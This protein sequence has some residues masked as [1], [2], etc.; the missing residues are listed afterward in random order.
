M[1]E[2]KLSERLNAIIN[3][4]QPPKKYRVPLLCVRDGIAAIEAKEVWRAE[5]AVVAEREI[6][7]AGARIAALE[8]GVL[9][10]EERAAIA[11]CV[12]QTEQNGRRGGQPHWMKQVAIIR[13]WLERTRS[14]EAPK[15][16]SHGGADGSV[17]EKDRVRASDQTS[18]SAPPEPH[19]SA[20]G[21]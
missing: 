5:L 12:G 8:S 10:E 17:S 13:D 6:Q 11:F 7:A 9:S 19:G 4:M 16:P 21:E 1:S 3:Q 20:Q 18:R 2:L 14:V 15:E